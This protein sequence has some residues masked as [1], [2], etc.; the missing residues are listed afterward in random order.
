MRV[1]LDQFDAEHFSFHHD[2]VLE[3][4]NFWTTADRQYFRGAMQQATWTSLREMPNTLEEF[5]NCGN[6]RKA[7]M[8]RVHATVLLDRLAMPCI[9]SY[10][11]SF[12]HIAQRHMNFNYYSYGAGDCLLTHDDT[13]PAKNPA[14]RPGPIRRL[15]LVTYLHDEWQPDWGGELIIYRPQLGQLTLSDLEI[16]HCIAP[17]PGSLVLFTV[18]RLHRVCRVD[19]VCGPHKRLSIAGW[20]MTEHEVPSTRLSIP[21][22]SFVDDRLLSSRT[23]AKR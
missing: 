3:I 2:P 13:P 4:N 10:I 19:P 21:A 11:E 7:D 1:T 18:P 12:P 15:A 5:P 22:P 9:R 20:F 14:K 17:K 23:D 6:W 16:A 8:A